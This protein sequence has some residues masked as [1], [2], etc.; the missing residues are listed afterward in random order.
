MTPSMP[1][2]IVCKELV[3]LVSDYL[4]GALPPLVRARFERHILLCDECSEYLEQ[5]RRTI[6]IAGRLREEAIPDQVKQGLLDA[7]RTWKSG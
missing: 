1:E 3:E 6:R 7:F 5:L 2:E 4:E